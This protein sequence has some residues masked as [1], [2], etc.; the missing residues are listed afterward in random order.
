MT[1]LKL[2]YPQSHIP[3]GRLREKLDVSRMYVALTREMLDMAFPDRRDVDLETL[4]VLLCVF[5]GDAEGRITTAAKLAAHSG[6]PRPSV[7]RRLKLLLKLKKVERVGRNYR[8]AQGAATPDER[9]RL[10]RILD[11]YLHK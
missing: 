8:L 11:R 4:V 5:I 9:G 7:D 10:A 3:P 2:Y 6:Q 1:E